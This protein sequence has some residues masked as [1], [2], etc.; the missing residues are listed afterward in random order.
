MTAV[1]FVNH[2]RWV[3]RC[4]RWVDG[5]REAHRVRPGDTFTC[6]N[7]GAFAPVEFPLE[8]EL[9]E[10]LLAVRP[11]PESRNWL[12]GES[13]SDLANENIEHGVI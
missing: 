8:S 3:A 9:V 1:A 4:P 11:V 7:C 6:G 2:G 12:P 13:L 5:C 10:A